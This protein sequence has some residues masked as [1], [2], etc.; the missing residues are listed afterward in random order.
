MAP[1]IRVD[2]EVF[3][4][5]QARAEAFVDSPNDVLRRL[6]GLDSEGARRVGERRRTRPRL[7]PGSATP[8]EE[9]RMPILKV[10]V[11]LGGK[12]APSDVVKGVGDMLRDRLTELDRAPLS[13]GAIRWEKRAN[14]ERY[15]MACEGLV[16][17]PR[18][19]WELTDRGWKEAREGEGD[20]P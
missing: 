19:M 2:D 14:W 1:T 20:G 16:A 12:G 5:L 11:G 13:S 9:F 10:L 18:G 8:K 3:K 7:A 4:A 15:A 17:G 6:L